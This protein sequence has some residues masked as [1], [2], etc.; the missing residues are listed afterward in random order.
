MQ[1]VHTLAETKTLLRPCPICG[2]SKGEALH[3]QKFYLPQGY[4]LPAEYDVVACAGCGFTYADV[5]VGQQA[6][7]FYY[8]QQSI[9]EDEK[10]GR[11]SGGS[12]YDR[13]RLSEI[14]KEVARSCPDKNARIVE[15]GCANGGIL[16]ALKDKGY[17]NLTGVDLSAKCVERL[18][19]CGIAGVQG[20]IS[21]ANW[22]LAGQKFDYVI[23]S[24][25]MEHVYDL[26]NAIRQCHNLMSERALL[27]L[28]V[29]DA[30]RYA[31]FYIDPYHHFNI[32]HI[33]HFDEASLTNMGAR[34]C[35]SKRY[36]GRKTTSASSTH[37]YPAVFVVF[38]K[39][40]I[41]D[42][43]LKFS[44]EARLSIEKYL[45]MS[46]KDTSA[47]SIAALVKTQEEVYVF[48]TGNLTYRLLATTDLAKCNIKAFVDNDS[49]KTTNINKN[50]EGGG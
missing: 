13:K 34:A 38:E 6:Y 8:R 33:N 7:D 48:G 47:E 19:A 29:P 3:T 23:L 28:E 24:H 41:E 36:A 37:S 22:L 16:K 42:N 49:N 44:T 12:G 11:G 31:D 35:L 46:A 27:Y 26:K 5:G 45:D 21:D 4:P 17:S 25:I 1:N 30:T 20:S 9:Y 40:E 39:V 2:S 15:I 10:I 50:Y 14:A 43:S 32:E 18:S